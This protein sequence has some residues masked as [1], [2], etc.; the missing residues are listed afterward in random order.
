[1]KFIKR[2]FI[3]I[4]LIVVV[5][6]IAALFMK[7]DYNIE[8]EVSIDKSKNEV[9]TYIK[10]LKNQDNYSYW[11]KQD[12]NMKKGFKGTDGE[13]G[14]IASWEGNDKVGIGE[15]EIKAIKEGERLDFELRFKKP[16][17]MT[18]NA[19]MLT[20]STGDDQTKVKWGF[21]GTMPYPMNIIMPFGSMDK[22][23]G[24]Q[25]QS[26]LNDLKSIMERTPASSMQV[27]SDSISNEK[28]SK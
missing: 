8:R 9:F 6:L 24:D 15:Q 13:V 2:F 21:N 25:L 23:L 27:V 1:M 12:P 22:M 26:G 3:I 14:A 19:Y 18:N 7:K 20:E 28:P 5:A 10:H 16:N 11:N 4:F 17:E